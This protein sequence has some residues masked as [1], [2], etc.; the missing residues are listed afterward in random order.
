[1]G[2]GACVARAWMEVF[3]VRAMLFMFLRRALFIIVQPYIIAHPIHPRT[4]LGTAD[5]PLAPL[6]V[7]NTARQLR[8]LSRRSRRA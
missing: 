8:G 2:D 7:L 3:S 6:R 1:M 5:S 4:R